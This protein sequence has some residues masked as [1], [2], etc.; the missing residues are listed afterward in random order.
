MRATTV[1]GVLLLAAL[2]FAPAQTAKAQ[3]SQGTA[4]Q[5]D[6]ARTLTDSQKQAIKSIQADAERRAAAAA[7]RL[8]GIV[9]K[10]YAN[11]L[12]DKPDA[13]LRATLSARMEK[14]TW[15]LLSIKGQSVYETLRVLT[16]AQRQL[17]RGE[18]RKPGAPMALSE[19]VARVFKLEEK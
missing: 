18:M 7:L 15:T 14:A 9:S 2:S 5:A 4:A 1:F 11:M 6:P 13:R 17:V 19:V 3:A 12:A 16:P 10:V 8:A